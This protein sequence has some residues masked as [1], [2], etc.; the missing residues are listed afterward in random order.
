MNEWI[1]ST[2]PEQ[3]RDIAL[4]LPITADLSRSDLLL[5][6]PVNAEQVLVVAQAQ[7]HSI[8]PLYIEDL[9]HRTLTGKDAPLIMESW[10]RRKRI[11]AQRELPNRAPVMQDV[12][13]IFDST[14][15]VSALLSIE[16]SLIQLE[17][18]RQRHVS[19]RRA[20]EW[21]KA[22]CANGNLTQT[23]GLTP[24][25]EMDGVLLVDP[26]R[27]I[28][29]MS[30]IANNLYRR[31]G[32]MEDLRGKRL[33][34]LNTADDELVAEA[35]AIRAPLERQMRYGSRIWVHKVLPVWPSSTGWWL[36]RLGV[37]HGGTR[38]GGALIMIHDATEEHR[39]QE[40]L[41]VKTTMIQEVHH[42]VKNNLQTIAAVLRMQARRAHDEGTQQALR[43][44]IARILSV[45]VI[46]E[47]LSLDE[48]Q[49]INVRDVCQ[50]IVA[51]TRQVMMPRRQISFTVEGP[52]VYL[53]SQQATACAL[54]I[55]ELIQNA[56]EHG[57]QDN[58][59]G[60]I[61]IGLE[62][63]GDRVRIEI[64]D[65]GNPLPV[66]FSLDSSTS[67]GLQIVRTLVEGDLHGQVTLE[68]RARGVAATVIFQKVTPGASAG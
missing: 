17:R 45:A 65:D 14:R 38:L 4:G 51:Q 44:A 21:L 8:S 50:R 33:S 5:L 28:T 18:H 2:L 34:Y 13:P 42:R 36:G 10:R 37:G 23:A 1:D 22:M 61:Q 66:D 19:F 11:I 25:R 62:D 64:W 26:Q 58:R 67:L 31:L 15:Q 24:F 32:Y 47:F 60:Q 54:V 46:H 9:R 49:F 35:F 39:R 20:V 12:R 6:R 52:I 57:Y 68:N 30:G 43:E 48:R 16:T 63:L 3:L 40:E 59:T 41:Q 56:L 27:R 29:Y 7:P 53:P 55:N